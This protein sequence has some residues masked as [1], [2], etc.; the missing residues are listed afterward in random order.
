ML[1]YITINHIAGICRHT[2]RI[3]PVWQAIY[4]EKN[5]LGQLRV[6]FGLDFR[7]NKPADEVIS[8]TQPL[9][10]P[11]ISVHSNN[12]PIHEVSPGDTLIYPSASVPL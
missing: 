1:G 10:C 11:F 12:P 9:S 2:D 5:A 3:S 6:T 4:R 7:P 8:C